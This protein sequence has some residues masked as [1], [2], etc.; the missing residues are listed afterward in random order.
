MEIDEYAERVTDRSREESDRLI[1]DL[2]TK[3]NSA[4]EDV[5]AVYLDIVKSLKAS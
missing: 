3:A 4:A 1:L 2:V 5:S